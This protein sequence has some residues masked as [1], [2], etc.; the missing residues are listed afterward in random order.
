M[1]VLIRGGM[2]A[3]AR[4]L[5]IPSRGRDGGEVMRL[6]SAVQ[7]RWEEWVVADP[8]LSAWPSLLGLTRP[9]SFRLLLAGVLRATW[10][11]I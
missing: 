9:R 10:P 8:D 5:P 2:L 7:L 11:A 6:S 3:R 4:P 1:R